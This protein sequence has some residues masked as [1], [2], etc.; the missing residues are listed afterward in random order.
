MSFP[1]VFIFRYT[2]STLGLQVKKKSFSKLFV[3][4]LSAGFDSVKT[5]WDFIRQCTSYREI[6][7]LIKSIAW[8]KTSAKTSTNVEKLTSLRFTVKES[9]WANTTSGSHYGDVDN[10][11][12]TWKI[13]APKIVMKII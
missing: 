1:F 3:S 9:M 2:K 5:F 11:K 10:F 6:P 12:M 8:K 7:V 13:I 4:L